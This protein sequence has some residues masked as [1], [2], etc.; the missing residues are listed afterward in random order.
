MSDIEPHPDSLSAEYVEGLF[1]DYLQ[2]PSRLDPAWR[3]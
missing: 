2:D 3:R 1:A